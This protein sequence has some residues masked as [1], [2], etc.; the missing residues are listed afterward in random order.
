[1]GS[2]CSSDG[3]AV[4]AAAV[5]SQAYEK[6]GSVHLGTKNLDRPGLPGS[7][8]QFSGD[9]PQ[10]RRRSS[11]DRHKQ[12]KALESGQSPEGDES[13]V[14]HPGRG[15]VETA[16]APGALLSTGGDDSDG[17]EP[18][19]ADLRKKVV[20]PDDWQHSRSRRRPGGAGG[21][22]PS[23]SGSDGG[24]GHQSDG[25]MR[26]MGGAVGHG[27]SGKRAAGKS[28]GSREAPS[29][30]R[31]AGSKGPSPPTS[32]KRG[33]PGRK[34]ARSASKL[35]MPHRRRSRGARTCHACPALCC[36]NLTGR[37]AVVQ[38]VQISSLQRSP[39]RGCR[40]RLAASS[41][42][43]ARRLRTVLLARRRR[44]GRRRARQRRLR[45]AN[46]TW[47][48]SLLRAPPPERLP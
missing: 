17:D 41:G 9:S 16:G 32:G 12:R 23:T 38:Q 19:L 6:T 18:N 46:G 8:D 14:H 42:S 1:M 31:A 33:A 21:D 11:V 25:E 4:A 29:Q 40:P 15:V 35:G 36:R 39:K 30:A 13:A 2:A 20:L 24:S 43:L 27:A 10:Q 22:A 7:I 48:G 37:R 47:T 28:P 44:R 45:Q 26:K 5:A 3:G 34:E